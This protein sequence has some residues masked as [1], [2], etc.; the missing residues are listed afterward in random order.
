MADLLLSFLWTIAPQSG[1]RIGAS[2]DPL[3]RRPH[4]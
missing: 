2:A 1:R 4:L 3:A